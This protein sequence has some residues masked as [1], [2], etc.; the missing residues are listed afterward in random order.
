[1]TFLFWK[2][3]QVKN[4]DKLSEYFTG[5]ALSRK[6]K[7]NWITMFI[8]FGTN[9]LQQIPRIT[10][11]AGALALDMLARHCNVAQ[12]PIGGFTKELLDLLSLSGYLSLTVSMD[13]FHNP[14][15]DEHDDN[16][17]NEIW[18]H[19]CDLC[20]FTGSCQCWWSQMTNRVISVLISSWL[21]GP[22]S[23]SLPHIFTI[24]TST[25]LLSLSLSSFQPD[26]NQSE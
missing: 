2:K 15:S 8:H 3:N 7:W 22:G 25:S 11:T 17:S 24:V 1:M 10:F 19:V 6:F 13:V 20:L 26:S 18:D 5:D 21:I 14:S 12:D 4:P 9:L 23:L 16:D